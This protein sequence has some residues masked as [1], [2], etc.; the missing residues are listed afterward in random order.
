[1]VAICGLILIEEAGVP[2]PFAPGDLLLVVAGLLIAAGRMSAEVFIPLAMLAALLGAQAAYS[3]SAVVGST[4]LGRLAARM[5]VG[6]RFDRLSLRLRSASPVGIAVCRLIPGMRVYTSMACGSLGVT[7]KVFSVAVV[8]SVI[9]WVLTFV[10]LGA[11]VGAPAERLLGGLDQLALRG[12]LLAAAGVAVYVTM[13][14]LPARLSPRTAVYEIETSSWGRITLALII[15][16]VAIAA[17]VAGLD[18]LA[19]AGLR[20]GG[21]RSWEDGTAVVVVTALAYLL[22]SRIGVGVTAGER[23]FR[24]S[25]RFKKM[26]RR[27]AK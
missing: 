18:A 23:L 12:A 9:I 15:D 22:A 27:G 16:L 21:F 5:G 2:L 19:R 17:T 1:M 8:P 10:A 3:W 6:E 4:A 25:Y 26:S 7:R 24:I 14:F 20:I 13:R 11:V